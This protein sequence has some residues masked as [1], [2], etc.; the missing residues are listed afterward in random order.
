MSPQRLGLLLAEN[1]LCGAYGFRPSEFNHLLAILGQRFG[2][3]I[4]S[5]HPEAVKHVERGVVSHMRVGLATGEDRKMV[6]TVTT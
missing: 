4:L 2:L 5:S 3:E 6:C 1:K